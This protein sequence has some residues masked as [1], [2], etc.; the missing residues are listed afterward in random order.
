MIDRPDMGEDESLIGG[1]TRFEQ[2]EQVLAEIQ[3]GTFAKEWIA[4]NHEGQP[5]FKALREAGANHEIEQ[6]GAN[7]RQMMSFLNKK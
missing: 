4:E 1:H 5:R 2:W 7:L 6:V 3:D